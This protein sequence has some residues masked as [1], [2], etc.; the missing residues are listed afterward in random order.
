MLNKLKT[1]IRDI[2]VNRGG[3]RASRQAEFVPLILRRLGRATITQHHQWHSPIFLRLEINRPAAT[4]VLPG[5]QPAQPATLS[6]LQQV[7][8]RDEVIERIVRRQIRI[9]SSA[10]SPDQPVGNRALTG[11]P[12]PPVT[13]PMILRTPSPLPAPTGAAPAAGIA[14]DLPRIPARPAK[15]DVNAIDINRLTEQVV[16]A[17][18]RRISAW[19]ERTGRY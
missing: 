12:P 18:D 9:E 19:R 5:D 13:P 7:S 3:R 4:M 6:V 1:V 14:V 8:R 15:L 16:T 2:R 11:V 17:I 10:A